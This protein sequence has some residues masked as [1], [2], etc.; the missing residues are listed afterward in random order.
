M[1]QSNTSP[2]SNLHKVTC[3]IYLIIKKKKER[4]NNDIEVPDVSYLPVLPRYVYGFLPSGHRMAVGC[5]C[6][7]LFKKERGGGAE[8]MNLECATS[9]YGLF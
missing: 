4:A 6:S 2:T 1:Y 5:L 7:R 3:Q 8:F 9:V